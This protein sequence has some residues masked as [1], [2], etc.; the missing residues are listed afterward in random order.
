MR[1][2]LDAGYCCK[3]RHVAWSVCLSVGHDLELC[4]TGWTDQDAICVTDARGPKR[5]VYYTAVHI[6]ADWRIRKIALRCCGGSTSYSYVYCSNLFITIISRDIF[7][8][9]NYVALGRKF[10]SVNN[11]YAE[12]NAPN[13]SNSFQSDQ[14]VDNHTIIAS[15]NLQ[16]NT[17]YHQLHRLLFQ[18]YANCIAS[19]LRFFLSLLALI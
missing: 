9:E 17:F 5:A 4:K 12:L 19:V 18:F 1:V 15:S 2:V 8:S 3:R 13:R 6:G 14:H 10:S 16:R 11:L 7:Q